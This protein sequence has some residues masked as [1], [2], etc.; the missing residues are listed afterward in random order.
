MFFARTIDSLAGEPVPRYTLNER[1][2]V[3]WLALIDYLNTEDMQDVQT[4]IDREDERVTFLP[5]KQL[6]YTFFISLIKQRS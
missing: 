1:Q 6:C 5:V 4:A 2:R 3:A